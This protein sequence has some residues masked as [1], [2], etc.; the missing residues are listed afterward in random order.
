M[1]PSL[2]MVGKVICAV[3]VHKA[4]LLDSSIENKGNIK[5]NPY[6]HC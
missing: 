2:A 6:L 4:G 1:L 5:Y 3:T